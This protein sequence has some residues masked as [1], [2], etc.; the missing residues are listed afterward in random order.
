MATKP[1]PEE[2]G[3]TYFKEMLGHPATLGGGLMSITAGAITLAVT[4]TFSFALLPALGFAGMVSIASLFVPS[5]PVFRDYINRARKTQAREDERAILIEEISKT[6]SPPSTVGGHN[7]DNYTQDAYKGYWE[8]YVRMVDR[9]QSLKKIAASRDTNI[10][11]REMERLDEATLD[12]LRLFHARIM[13]RERMRNSDPR[14]VQA[15]IDQLE[16]QLKRVKSITDRKK[17]EQAREDLEKILDRASGLQA[18]DSTTAASMLAMSD[19]FEEVCQRIVANPHTGVTE[20]LK[21]A[22]EKLS[23]EEDLITSAD[24]EIDAELRRARIESQRI[25]Q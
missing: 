5:S 16:S 11:N 23:I 25:P 22:E 19:T 21:D 18:R 20:T 6:S 10:T 4:G 24:M 12:F 1:Q 13:Y 2:S 9:L 15:Q 7:Y 14:S 3:L 8:R 17:L